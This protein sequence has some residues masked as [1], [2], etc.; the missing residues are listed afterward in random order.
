MMTETRAR[1]IISNKGKTGTTIKERGVI[2][3][4]GI[5]ASKP[6]R[7]TVLLTSLVLSVGRI[8]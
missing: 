4:Q 8:S 7:T 2:K 1:R 6:P 5:P 3:L